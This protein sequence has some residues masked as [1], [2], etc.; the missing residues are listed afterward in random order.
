WTAALYLLISFLI[1]A[2][3]V[4]FTL[5]ILGKELHPFF[6]NPGLMFEKAKEAIESMQQKAGIILIS[7][8]TLNEFKKTLSALAGRF[9]NNT[10][11]LVANQA[12]LLFVLYYMLVHGREIESYLV[13]QIPLK[14]SNISLLA[15]E[16]SRLIKASAIGIP[17]ISII[18]G[19]TAT[20]GYVI[21][22]VPDYLLWGFLTCVFAFFPVVGTMII[23][24][25]LVIYVYIGGDTLNAIGLFFYSL[26]ITGNIDYV[27]GIT[28]L[29]KIGHV[30]PVITVFGVIIGLSLFGFIGFI[31]GPLLLNYIILILK[32]YINEFVENSPV[33]R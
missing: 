8:E 17:L 3:L 4:Y 26:I 1:P 10:V 18:Q 12:I 28:F 14:K 29:K 15:S 22:G 6:S 23:W 24:V 25:P 21:F 7:E 16:T 33:K 32:I 31:F 2:S 20:I 19:I 9:V 13:K 5:I 11:N 27:A 30:H